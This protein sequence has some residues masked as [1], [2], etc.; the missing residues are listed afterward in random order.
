MDTSDIN[1]LQRELNC[2]GECAVEK[3]MKVNPF[4]RKAV[5]F[6]KARTKNE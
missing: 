4:K 1:V 3:E 2:L 5:S 6:A